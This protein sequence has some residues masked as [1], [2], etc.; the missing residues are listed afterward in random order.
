MCGSPDLS[1]PKPLDQSK[2][3]TVRSY[4]KLSKDQNEPK[5]SPKSCQNRQIG[6]KSPKWQKTPKWRKVLKLGSKGFQGVPD[7]S[8]SQTAWARMTRGTYARAPYAFA[9]LGCQPK[10]GRLVETYFLK[11]MSSFNQVWN[12][13][14]LTFAY[15]WDSW[16]NHRLPWAPKWW[17]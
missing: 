13:W 1:S 9:A 7:D 14:P 10:A 17:S 15:L 5:K 11:K 12:I 2:N 8:R 4:H 6:K 3:V 16:V